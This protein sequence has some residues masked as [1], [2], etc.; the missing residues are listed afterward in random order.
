MSYPRGATDEQ[1]RVLR[2][3]RNT[4][5]PKRRRTIAGM[6]AVLG[7]SESVAKRAAYGQRAYAKVL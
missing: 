3:W 4:P 1:V 7:I 2:Q 6:A 5:R